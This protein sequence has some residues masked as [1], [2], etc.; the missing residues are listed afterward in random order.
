MKV[1]IIIPDLLRLD[2]TLN[3][4]FDIL[5]RDGGKLAASSP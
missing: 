1:A 2:M 5:L 3:Q 4:T